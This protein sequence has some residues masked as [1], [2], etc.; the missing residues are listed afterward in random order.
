MG[1]WDFDIP[2]RNREFFQSDTFKNQIPELTRTA[3]QEVLKDVS[4]DPKV[5]EQAIKVGQQTIIERL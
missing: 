3:K 1:D 5:Y 4:L 2:H